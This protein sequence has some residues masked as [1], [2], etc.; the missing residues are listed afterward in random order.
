[1]TRSRESPGRRLM[2]RIDEFAAF[3]DE[4][5][6]LTRLYLSQA[7][8][9]AAAQFIAWA[10]AI[11]LDARIDAGGNV[12]ARYEGRKTGAP[13][14]MIGS[15]IDTVRDAGRYDG[16]LGAL[17]AL[18]VVEELAGN[19]ERLDGAREIVAFG[20]EEGVRFPKTMTGS[21]ELAGLLQDGALDQ[22][23]AEGIVMR[24][25]L[26]AFGGDPD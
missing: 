7:H 23:D 4:P 15:H 3:T 20:D 14:L 6:K 9:R 18:A 26:R 19:G 17:A 1:M 12:V 8:R 10:Q 16:N 13:A 21:R 11:G 25:A 22:R 2:A 5:G 24:D